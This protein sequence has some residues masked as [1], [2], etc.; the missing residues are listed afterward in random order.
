[1]EKFANLAKILVILSASIITVCCLTYNYYTSAVS[2]DDSVKK[3]VVEQNATYSTL[4]IKL[5]ENNLIKSEFFYKVYIKLN[6]PTNLQE[7][8]YELSEDMSVNDIVKLLNE[9]TTYNPDVIK[10]VFPEGKQIKQIAEIIA[11]NTNHSEE[12][13]L[14]LATN[15]KYIDEL[16]KKYWFLTDDILKKTIY[17]PLEGYLFPDTYEFM[18]KDVSVETI[19][20]TM[21]DQMDKKLTQLKQEIENSKYSIHEIITLASMIQSEGNNVDDFK[22]MAS[23]FLTRLKKGMLLQSCA[24]AYYGDKKIMGKD[25]FGNSYLKKNAYNTYVVKGLPAGAISNPGL[26]A[27]NAVL[28]PSDSEYLYFASDKNMKVYF[29]KTLKEHEKI[30]SKL[31]KDG[32]WYGS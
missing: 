12:E 2:K 19:F 14:S 29:S 1:M 18:N 30:I 22:N 9:G 10:I 24:S 31:K 6:N 32:N 15:Q 28:N 21:L 16:I 5:K 25:E 8:V 13:V 23:I 27:L 26:D 17:Y 20:E 11:N 7:G 4:G 3:F